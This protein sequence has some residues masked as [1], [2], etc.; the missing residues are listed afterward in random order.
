MHN[1]L[2]HSGSEFIAKE[3]LND[4]AN[5][6]SIN[7][8]LQFLFK[9][10]VKAQDFPLRILRIIIKLIVSFIYL[11]LAYTIF[12]PI[13]II[14]ERKSRK[15]SKKI[16]DS[17][18]QTPTS[19]LIRLHKIFIDSKIID[20]IIESRK[21]NKASTPIVL[22]PLLNSINHNFDSLE[23]LYNTINSQIELDKKMFSEA[24]DEPMPEWLN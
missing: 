20:K 19:E 2:P 9:S 15:I 10:Y 13:S 1:T 21:N 3:V 5:F 18:S 14:V 24:L 6:D 22:S 16:I 23:E 12:Y 8:A 4:I 17:I 11:I 7:K